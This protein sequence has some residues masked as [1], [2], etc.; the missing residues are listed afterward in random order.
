MRFIRLISTLL[1]GA[2]AV[3]TA[4]AAPARSPELTVRQFME[5][6]R[7]GHDPDAASNYFAPVVQAHQ[8]TSEGETT[9]ART[10][11]QY[12][13]HVRGFK[14]A[15]GEYRFDIEELIAQGDRVYVRWRQQG[16]HL[17]SIDGE[18]PTGAPLT[19]IGSAVYR[20]ENGLIV[21]Y[22]IQLDR[23]GLELQLERAAHPKTSP[24]ADNTP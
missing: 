20:V 24:A 21:E 13:G 17:G 7:S 1:G 2:L 19:E 16:S 5:V 12:A 18:T 9:V 15:F 11:A 22:W 6:V 23:R 4:A 8:V 10:P 14:E 3:G